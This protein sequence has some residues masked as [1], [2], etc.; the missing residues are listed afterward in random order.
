M[1]TLKYL[2]FSLV[3]VLSACSKDDESSSES[4]DSYDIYVVGTKEL[5]NGSTRAMYWKNGIATELLPDLSSKGTAVVV[6]NKD[7]YISGN[8]GNQACYWKNGVVTYLP[9]GDQAKD[10][11][12]VGSDVYV[13]G[14]S[15]LVACYWKND[16]K[17][18]LGNAYGN[19]LANKI[20]IEGADVY[21][22]G[23][24]LKVNSVMI[25]KGFIGK[26]I[27]KIQL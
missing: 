26:I 24:H 27:L 6:V 9:E 21:I 13:A 5:A 16:V 2:L 11:K 3:I 22:A 25:L 19:S 10:I 8:I 4:F 18:T 15:N 17:T 12:V 20:I 14:S 1:K 7:V 23:G